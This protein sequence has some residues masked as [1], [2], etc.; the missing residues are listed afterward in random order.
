M[1]WATAGYP[2]GRLVRVER[3]RI[4]VCRYGGMVRCVPQVVSEVQREVVQEGVQ[5]QCRSLHLRRFRSG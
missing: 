3:W 1:G 5:V 2:I 4:E